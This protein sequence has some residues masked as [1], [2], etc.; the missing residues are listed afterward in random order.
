MATK[1][2]TAK[3][4]KLPDLDWMTHG[5]AGF[6]DV[7]QDDLGF[8]FLTMMQKGSPEIDEDSDKHVEGLKVGDIILTTTK[9]KY[10]DKDT[11][12][13]VVPVGY[14]KAFVE[15]RDRDSGGGYVGTHGPAILNQCTKNDKGQD[16]LGSG[17]LIVTTAYFM[18]KLLDPDTDMYEDA[19]ISMTST[20]LKKA[21]QWLNVMKAHTMDNGKGGKFLLPM[22]SHQYN[23]TTVG[24]S[25]DDYTWKGWHIEVAD[26]LKDPALVGDCSVAHKQI[27]EGSM[28]MLAA[29]ADGE[30]V[31]F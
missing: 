22:F 12:A 4:E 23:L 3:K 19:V 5:G 21:R 27:V 13:V 11:P 1:K 24:E 25:K 17:N 6:E 28:N 10:G 30:E 9:K 8:P 2:T 7:T 16:V 31:P 26:M 18:V 20:Q 15:W 14:K 29:P